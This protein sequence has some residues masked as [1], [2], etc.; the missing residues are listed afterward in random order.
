[1]VKRPSPPPRKTTGKARKPLLE[2]TVAGLGLV[3][4]LA[5]LG[6]LAMDLGSPTSP[7]DLSARALEI[8]PVTGGFHVEVEVANTGRATAAGVD[9]E[10]V[11]TPPTGAPET[12]TATLDYVA[13]N[14]TETLTLMFRADPR[15]APLELTVRGWSEP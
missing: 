1:M 6:V 2:W 14:G 11:L 7:P 8:T 4:T 15:A 9:V 5:T 3:L 13:G 12:A 10:G